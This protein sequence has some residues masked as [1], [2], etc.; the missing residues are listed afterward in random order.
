MPPPK[1]GKKLTDAQKAILDRW[2]EQGAPYAKHWAFERAEAGAAA[3]AN[4]GGAGRRNPIDAF[5]LRAAREAKGLQPVAGGRSLHACRRV[6]LDLIGLPPTPEEADAFVNDSVAR[7]PTRSSSIACSP[8]R[9]TASAGRGAGSTSPATPTPTAT[10]RTAPRSIWPYRDWVINALNADMPFDQFTIEQLAGDMLPNATL[11]A[12]HRH[13]LSPQHDAQRGRRHR[14]ARVPLP[15]DDR[16]RR[17]HRHHLARADRRLRPVPHAQVR[18]R[19]RTASTTSSWRSSTT[20]TSRTR[21]AVPTR[22]ARQRAQRGEDR[23][24]RSPSC[25]TNGRWPPTGTA[26]RPARRAAAYEGSSPPGSQRER[27]ARGA[28]DGR[29][30][31]RGEVEPAAAHGAA[32]RLGL[33]SAATSPRATPTT[34]TFRGRARRASPRSGWKRCPTSACRRTARACATTKGRR[35]ISS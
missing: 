15:R 20:P 14:P 22:I 30:V 33:R 28:L 23:R 19:S 29:C 21:S 1:T 9:T 17:H 35:A 24:A 13:R 26:V 31:R 27:G 12:A 34:L 10:R 6:S 11:D 4:A 5:V 8:R 3:G 2:I 25:R 18:S 32:G 16:S 7:T